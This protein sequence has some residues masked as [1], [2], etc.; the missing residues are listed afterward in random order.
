[1]T[2]FTILIC[3]FVPD[4]HTIFLQILDVCFALQE[5]KELVDNRFQVALFS[6][7]KWETIGEVEAH[8]VTKHR[9]CAR[10]RSIGLDNTF[11]LDAAEKVEVLFHRE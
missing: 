11:F 10:A 7:D 3:P 2:K 8:L 1:M 9:L 4:A 6:S 5:P